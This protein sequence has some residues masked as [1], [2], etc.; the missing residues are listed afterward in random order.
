MTALLHQAR[1][2]LHRVA[3]AAAHLQ[4]AEAGK[5]RMRRHGC[6]GDKVEDGNGGGLPCGW[7]QLLEGGRRTEDRNEG[8]LWLS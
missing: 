4:R 5:G 8:G 3:R 1:V 2:A 6:S 7:C